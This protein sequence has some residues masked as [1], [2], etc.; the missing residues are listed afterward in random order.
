MLVNIRS[1]IGKLNPTTRRATEEAAGLCL[2]KT[3]YDIEIEHYLLKLLDIGKSDFFY[4]LNRFDVDGSNLAAQLELTLSALK[5]GNT[6]TPALSPELVTMFTQA[7][8]VGSLE[9]DA[10]NIRTGHTILALFHGNVQW[11]VPNELRKIDTTILKS[12]FDQIVTQSR[13]TSDKPLKAPPA[14]RPVES[15]KL[16][17]FICYRRED[18]EAYAGRL[19]D[20]IESAI[21]EAG[22]FMDINTIQPGDVFSDVIEQTVSSCDVLIAVIGKRWLKVTDRQGRRRLDNEQDW[23]RLEIGT[24]L[25]HKKKVIPCLVDGARMPRSEELPSD[26]ADLAVRQ[27]VDISEHFRR[28]TETLIRALEQLKPT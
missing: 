20:R 6:R 26:L 8:T 3:N 13:E 23:V 7:W 18:S 21:K 14:T 22:V 11:N 15:G 5:S 10:D 19:F 4:I 17:I 28:D 2:A 16:R 9:F 25:K 24:A 1:L 12:G 27:R